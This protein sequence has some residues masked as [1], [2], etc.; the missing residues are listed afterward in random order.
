MMCVGGGVSVCCA[1]NDK[2]DD[3]D[4]NGGGVTR[5]GRFKAE[6]HLAVCISICVFFVLCVHTWHGKSPT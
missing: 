1:K 5:F 6:S 4:D 3:D 2:D